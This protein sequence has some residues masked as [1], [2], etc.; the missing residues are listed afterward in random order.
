MFYL[1][2]YPQKLVK[3]PLILHKTKKLQRIK[4]STS[5]LKTQSKIVFN[6]T[7]IS[8]LLPDT[9]SEDSAALPILFPVQLEEKKRKQRA[10][11]YHHLSLMPRRGGR[12][13]RHVWREV[14]CSLPHLS[15][16]ANS[17]A[18][19][20]VSTLLGRRLMIGGRPMLPA[21]KI[22]AGV[23]LLV[24]NGGPLNAL[25]AGGGWK[26]VIH[27]IQQAAV[28]VCTQGQSH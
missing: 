5:I 15:K 19:R 14:S 3:S 4:H 12:R 25:R 16:H 9:I 27:A 7:N 8:K 21:R 10:A 2:D 1:V 11:V 17:S 24:H 6:P 28:S 18:R 20:S 13:G 22:T 23:T 26:R